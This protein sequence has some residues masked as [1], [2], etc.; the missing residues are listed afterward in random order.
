MNVFLIE[1]VDKNAKLHV[2]RFLCLQLCIHLLPRPAS[3][4][5]PG[6]ADS[7]LNN[8]KKRNFFALFRKLSLESW[9]FPRCGGSPPVCLPALC[10]YGG[11]GLTVP[12]PVTRLS[13]AGGGSTLYP[14]HIFIY[15]FTCMYT[16]LLLH[17]TA[18]YPSFD[19]L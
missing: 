19:S 3:R 12:L 11:R 4:E 10:V 13:Q 15:I 2:Y 7:S 5:N 6:D 18:C 9:V 14:R 17:S 8:A 16:F 1:F